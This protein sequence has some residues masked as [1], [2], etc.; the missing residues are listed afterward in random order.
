MHLLRLSAGHAYMQADDM[1]CIK[2]WATMLQAYCKRFAAIQ[3][4]MALNHRH[5][6]LEDAFLLFALDKW[7]HMPDLLIQVRLVLH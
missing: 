1:R 5:D 3:R 4:Y 7:K 6:M 2:L